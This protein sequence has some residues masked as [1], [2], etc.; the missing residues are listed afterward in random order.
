MNNPETTKVKQRMPSLP[1]QSVPTP[2]QSGFQQYL[3]LRES[4]STEINTPW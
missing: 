2:R 3:Q 1:G 4:E